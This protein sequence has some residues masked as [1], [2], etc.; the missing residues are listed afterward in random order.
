MQNPEFGADDPS[1]NIFLSTFGAL[2]PGGHFTSGR[3]SGK[4]NFAPTGGAEGVV[5]THPAPV[6]PG[7]IRRKVPTAAVAGRR[8]ALRKKLAMAM[9]GIPPPGGYGG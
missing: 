5:A 4:T 9:G 7:V 1:G 6:T 2:D 8:D 3:Y